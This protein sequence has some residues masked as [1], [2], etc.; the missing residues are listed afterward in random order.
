MTRSASRPRD[1]AAM[2][3]REVD[4]DKKYEVEQS[5]PTLPRRSKELDSQSEGEKERKAVCRGQPGAQTKPE[6]EADKGEEGEERLAAGE[7]REARCASSSGST[8]A[9]RDS[10]TKC[11]AGTSVVWAKDVEDALVAACVKVLNYSARKDLERRTRSG[12]G[13]EEKGHID[14]Y[15]DA[16]RRHEPSSESHSHAAPPQ[17]NT[18]AGSCSDKDSSKESSKESPHSH[19]KASEVSRCAQSP[20]GCPSHSPAAVGCSSSS[21]A[22]CGEFPHPPVYRFQKDGEDGIGAMLDEWTSLEKLREIAGPVAERAA[23]VYDNVKAKGEAEGFELSDAEEKQLRHDVLKEALIREIYSRICTE[24][25]R[26]RLRDCREGGLLANPKG[27]REGPLSFL[28]NETVHDLMKKGFAVQRGF[29]GEKMRQ[30]IWKETELLEFDGR[31][32]EVFSQSLHD[33]RSDYMCWMSASDLD[34][35]TQQGLW[36]LFKAMQALP[37]ELNKKASLC[38]QVSWVFQMAMFRAD[39]AFYKKHIDAGYDPALDN[40]RKV[41]AIYYPNPPDWEAKDGG[42][43]RIYP[44]RRKDIQLQEDSAA[45]PADAEPLVDIKPLGDTLVLFRSRDMP[46]EVLPCHRK[47]FA[48]SLWMTGPAGPGDDV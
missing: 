25:R 14:C 41:T 11:K 47:R 5:P 43:L 33:L 28:T 16:P 46:H 3:D 8:A 37:F 48:I 31:F 27:Y 20:C 19:K 17:A 2:G 23:T 7:K 21:T 4:D 38:L 10:R 13:T 15:D 1:A 22:V 45:G 9:A 30:K 39:G 6:A 42:F 18:H 26:E 29:L 35:E 44:R 24:L 32:N 36:Q 40:G 12:T 34:R